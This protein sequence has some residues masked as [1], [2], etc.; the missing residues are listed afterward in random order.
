MEEGK[1]QTIFLSIIGIATLLV[2]IIGAT[3]AWFSISI[4][5]NE[6]ANDMTLTAGNLGQVNFADGATIDITN[7]IPGVYRTKTFTISQ[8]DPTATMNIEYSIMLNVRTNTI[9]AVSDGQFIHRMSGSGNTNGGIV[10]SFSDTLVPTQ[11]TV[12]GV[13]ELDGYEIHTYQYTIGL[14]NTSEE[15]NAAQGK[16]FS[17]YLSVVLADE[18]ITPYPPP[19]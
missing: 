12:I 11:S 14:N 7:L 9:S 13:G 8:T 15:Q 2:A 1:G 10:A 3:F 18:G 16:T 4:T 17:G 6:N 19:S 5:G